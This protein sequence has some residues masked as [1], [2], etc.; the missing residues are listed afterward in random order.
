M[1]DKHD[2]YKGKPIIDQS[3]KAFEFNLDSKNDPRMIKIG[4]ETTPAEREIIMSRYKIFVQ[5]MASL[6]RSL[7][8]TMN[9]SF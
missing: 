2:M 8:N 6:L 5:H 9:S 1:F 4:K 3:E 7:R